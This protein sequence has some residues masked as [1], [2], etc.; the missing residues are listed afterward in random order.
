MSRN[1]QSKKNKGGKRINPPIP[2][3][4]STD[5]EHP[6]FCFRYIQKG[7]CISDCEKEEKLSLIDSLLKRSKLSWKILKKTPHL[8]LGC[9]KIPKSS[10]KVDIPSS[11]TPDIDFIAFRFF[12]KMPMVGYRTNEIFH[13]VWIAREHDIY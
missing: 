1:I 10:I 3:Q 6:V 12:R 4:Q 9:E 8:K 11:I 2:I 13:I 7:Y 5:N